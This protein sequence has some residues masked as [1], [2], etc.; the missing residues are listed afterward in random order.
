[1]NNFYR[2]TIAFGL[3]VLAFPMLFSCGSEKGTVS[4]KADSAAYSYITAPSVEDS[5]SDTVKSEPKSTSYDPIITTVTAANPDTEKAITSDD[6]TP[7][8]SDEKYSS[9][10]ATEK[11]PE[12]SDD[13]IIL[14]TPHEQD[15]TSPVTTAETTTAETQKVPV[16]TKTS[17]ETT[18]TV[19]EGGWGPIKPLTK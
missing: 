7:V 14:T 18:T 17:E 4:E 1:M 16:T 19:E 13:V 2:V 9:T 15:T 8:T 11:V 5:S 10:E 3:A 12:T 6:K